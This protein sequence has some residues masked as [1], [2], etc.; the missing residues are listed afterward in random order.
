ME[1]PLA[2]A[3]SPTTLEIHPS[4]L[5][6]LPPLLSADRARRVVR[7]T[8]IAISNDLRPGFSLAPRGTSQRTWASGPSPASK[9][10]HEPVWW[11]ERNREPFRCLALA[12]GDAR[13]TRFMAPE[14]VRK[15]HGPFHEPPFGAATF[16]SPLQGSWPQ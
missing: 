15:E 1:C 14:Q 12:R 8:G 10:P 4:S 7:P 13:P 3:L 5:F 11:G 9:S 2:P 16:L 6:L